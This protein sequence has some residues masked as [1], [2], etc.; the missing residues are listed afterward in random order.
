MNHQ[1]AGF[2]GVWSR[3]RERLLLPITL[4]LLM[5][6]V[7]WLG[8]E[9]WRLLFQNTPAGNVALEGPVGAVDLSLRHM[10]V[11]GWFSG[12]RIYRVQGNAVYPPAS[13]LILW[14]FVGWL[15]FEV[16]RF[17]WA[18]VVLA[19]LVPLVRRFVRACGELPAE[20]R[21]LL[22]LVPLATYPVGATIGNG[23]VGILVLLCLLSSLP[24]LRSRAPSW[25][26]DFTIATIFL[27]ALVKPTLAAP[28]F[29][30]V[31]FSASGLR[32]A[33]LVCVGYAGLTAL[34]SLWQ[35]AGP[36]GL[37]RSWFGRGVHGSGWGAKHGEGSMRAVKAAGAAGEAGE[38]ILRISSINLHS[39]LGYLGHRRHIALASFIVLA[40]LALW[41]ILRR[42]ASMWLLMGVVGIVT[43]FYTY[44]GW[45]DDV[46]LLLPLIALVRVSAGH[47][48]F[49]LG[50]RKAAGVLFAAM[51]ISMLAPGGGYLFPYPWSNVYLI[52]QSAL[53]LVVLVFLA[54]TAGRSS[55][56]NV[57]AA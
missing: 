56:A 7:I 40:L 50:V 51:L 38:K 8:Y 37:M 10:E 26:R 41:A 34:A 32:P 3:Y 52:V 49:G 44:H 47:E 6:A 53:W 46:L 2:P 18:V 45:Y 35:P 24:L 20:E 42:R 17:L 21:R 29:L 23:Q 12:E 30:L 48:G 28:F 25:K 31:L 15:K 36:V 13:Y 14:P 9:G 27:I 33:A 11:A 16:A 1:V 57:P 22:M 54:W 43:R 55:G 39:L 19:T 4:L 5:V